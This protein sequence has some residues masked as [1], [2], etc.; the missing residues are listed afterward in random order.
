MAHL[1]QHL[2]PPDLKPHD[3]VRVVDHAHAVGLGVA[4]AKFCIRRHLPV[5]TGLRFS[6]KALTPSLKSA[7]VRMRALSWTAVATC[8]SSCSLINP[9]ISFLV[10]RTDDG[11][12]SISSLAISSARG[13]SWSGCSTSFTRPYRCA[14]A[15]SK[16]R[17]VISKSRAILW[18]T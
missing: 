4:H 1:A 9:L 18:P 15:A 16:R 17:A 3:E 12:F 11:L 8:A 7:V 6:K 13:M 5:H 2:H 14:S 10:A